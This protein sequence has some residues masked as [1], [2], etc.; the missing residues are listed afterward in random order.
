MK[1]SCC[2]TS[3]R[4]YVVLLAGALALLLGGADSQPEPKSPFDLIPELAGTMVDWRAVVDG[5]PHKGTLT[6]VSGGLMLNRGSLHGASGTLTANLRYIFT[7]KPMWDMYVSELFFGVVDPKFQDAIVTV[8]QVHLGPHGPDGN[9]RGHV[10]IDLKFPRGSGAFTIPIVAT[11]TAAGWHIRSLIN[12]SLD[13]VA[14]GYRKPLSVL[15]E[16]LGVSSIGRE[17]SFGFSIELENLGLPDYTP[18]GVP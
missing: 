17:V 13:F 4:Y 15:P 1:I 3:R 14:L 16:A 12:T 2:I 8:Q 9:R 5:K 11:P 7:G 6:R 18:P 10:E